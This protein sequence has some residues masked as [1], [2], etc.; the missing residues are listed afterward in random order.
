[1][2]TT[3]LRL[4]IP[5]LY[6]NNLRTKCL[7]DNVVWVCNRQYQQVQVAPLDTVADCVTLLRH[8]VSLNIE[9]PMW[10]RARPHLL[11]E[12]S[13][14]FKATPEATTGTLLLDTYVRH[15]G[16]SANQ[17]VAVPGGGDFSID[18]IWAA[19]EH[20]PQQEK[21]QAGMALLDEQ[22]DLELLAQADEDK[23]VLLFGIFFAFSAHRSCFACELLSHTAVC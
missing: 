21:R 11:I 15:V 5:F 10:R 4:S 22:H 18:K 3:R 14:F 17:I 7:S 23:C 19:P 8:L 2:G 9:P 1:M 13:V 12:G 16:L 6:K 20:V